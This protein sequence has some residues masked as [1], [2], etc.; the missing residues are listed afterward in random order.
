MLTVIEKVVFLQNV[1]VF[2]AVPS[3]QLALLAAIAEEVSYAAD[4]VVYAEADPADALYLVL[5]GKVKLHRDAEEIAVSG[6]KETFGVWAL[7]DDEPR[8]TTATAVAEVQLLRI[9]K[10][11]FIDVLADHVQIAEGVL[12]TVAGRLRKLIERVS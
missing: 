1:E 4:E 3:E 9:D 2:A 10:D 12:K 11:D 8:V 6:S 7:F 5:S